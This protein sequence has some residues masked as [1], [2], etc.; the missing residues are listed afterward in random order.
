M[1]DSHGHPDDAHHAGSMLA[2]WLTHL[3][4]G[5][6]LG[7]LVA[8]VMAMLH[9][10]SPFP[11]LERAGSDAAQ[12]MFAST[13]RDRAAQRVVLLGV[14]RPEIDAIV[15]KGGEQIFE[16]RLREILAAQPARLL[17]DLQV[18][19]D[20]PE[21]R[22]T[23]L[24]AV[25]DRAAAAHPDIPIVVAVPWR[26]AAEGHVAGTAAAL[27]TSAPN[28][29]M[30]VSLFEP[31]ADAVVRR[32]RGTICRTD[33][34]GGWV[35]IDQL[36][37]P[38]VG[39]TEAKPDAHVGTCVAGPELPI[40]F[41]AGPELL[42]PGSRGHGALRYIAP[43]AER[44]PDVLRGAVVLIGAVGSAA[45]DERMRTP[46][47]VMDGALVA[48]NAALT[49]ADADYVA[50]VTSHDHG[51][52]A[53]LLW[54]LLGGVAFVV[55]APIAL[56]AAW[57][58][59]AGRRRLAALAG[60]V[61]VPPAL[62][63]L[64]LL[65]TGHAPDYPALLVKFATV[66]LAAGIFALHALAPLMRPPLGMPMALWRL[67][68]FILAAV[69]AVL[70]VLMF[71]LFLAEQLLPAGW[72]VGSLLP[73][74]AVM[75]EAV[76]EGLKPVSGAIHHEVERRL[77]PRPRPRPLLLVPLVLL[78]AGA[79]AVQ[80]AR[81]AGAGSA[82]AC[83]P[84][85]AGR[86]IAVE[87]AVPEGTM[88]P[89]GV[90]IARG[91]YGPVALGECRHLRPGDVLMLSHGVRVHMPHA[92]PKPELGPIIMM[93][94]PLPVSEPPAALARFRAAVTEVVLP[95]SVSPRLPVQA[96]LTLP[97]GKKGTAAP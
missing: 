31:D 92:S 63:G 91:G 45:I 21:D 54:L 46:L 36:V 87:S 53:L 10:V 11:A 51:W 20:A 74:F 59:P 47:G 85:G 12:R 60:A 66:F 37:A 2:T 44:S 3:F 86:P 41:H 5:A 81:A 77:A 94:P 67:L 80:S 30:A 88:V 84:G 62:A 73:A 95:P 8:M 83:V 65:A 22:A 28:L 24:M 9:N 71:N 33:P 56:D 68:A 27:P 93:V 64:I 15:A 17:I 40:L 69:G 7:L 75:F 97:V 1:A 42:V 50:A 35:R 39:G 57:I 32:V 25:L 34:A 72:R 26:T 16:R 58:G 89:D 49:L 76:S 79:T 29:D 13:A 61:A 14:D 19:E 82:L 4:A 70:A 90:R 6:F 48:A 78:P 43:G 52:I 96:S 55:L 38:P 18:P 23:E